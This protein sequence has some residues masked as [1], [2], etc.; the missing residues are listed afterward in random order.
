MTAEISEKEKEL[1]QE[2]GDDDS[3]S[4]NPAPPSYKCSQPAA[5]LEGEPGISSTP[6]KE[7]PKEKAAM[8][9]TSDPS[10]H[11]TL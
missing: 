11:L 8:I 3:S 7:L 4:L 5:S 10:E 1:D 9:Y 2:T 6:V